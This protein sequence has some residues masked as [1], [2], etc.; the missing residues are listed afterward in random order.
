MGNNMRIL[1]SIIEAKTQYALAGIA[2]IAIMS[3]TTVAYAIATS[4]EDTATTTDTVVMTDTPAAIDLAA[5]TS[6]PDS[7]SP[8]PED[9][10]TSTPTDNTVSEPASATPIVSTPRQTFT[11]V[12]ATNEMIYTD[13]FTDGTKTVSFP[14]DPVID[15]DLGKP[16]AQNP[17]RPGLT[18]VSTSGVNRYDTPTGNLE[19]G[20]YVQQ[21]DGSYLVHVSSSTYTD[22][23][24]TNALP[25]RIV[26]TNTDP[27]T[28]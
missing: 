3:V 10:G 4:T 23:T 22:A 8:A 1:K 28:Q 9:V 5:P 15:A 12:H 21:S 19:I 16:D 20:D 13:Y 27:T 11:L 14:G 26:I 18:W 17:T 25:D 6:T 24:S 7:V 2:I